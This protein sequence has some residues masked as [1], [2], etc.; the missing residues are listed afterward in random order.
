MQ[1]LLSL[2]IPMYNMEKYIDECINSVIIPE[3]ADLYE[4]IIINDGSTDSSLEIA[5]KYETKHPSI[6]KVIDKTNGGYGSCFNLGKTLATGKYLKMLDSDDFFNKK[7]FSSYLDILASNNADVF[8]NDCIKFDDEIKK[9][10]GTYNETSEKYGFLNDLKSA[11]M[12]DLFL[13]HFA[14]KKELLDKCV[15]PDHTLYTDGLISISGI[16]KAKSFFYT[17]LPLYIYRINRAGQ[18][19]TASVYKSKY[20]DCI[21]VL[22]K[23]FEIKIEKENIKNVNTAIFSG[24]ESPY[25]FALKGISFQKFNHENYKEYKYISKKFKTAMKRLNCSISDIKGKLVKYSIMLP[26]F[27]SYLILKIYSFRG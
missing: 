11:L 8:I 19:I 16:A 1:K 25:Y 12:K 13:H 18:S 3:K 15:C 27:I 6:F 5:R 4:A 22:E 24:L 2:I 7:T 26:S 14:F 20:K 10:I 21:K 23:D 17:N 9:E